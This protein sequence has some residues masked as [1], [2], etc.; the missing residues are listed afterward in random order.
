MS[1]LISSAFYRRFRNSEVDYRTGVVYIS[2]SNNKWKHKYSGWNSTGHATTKKWKC[3]FTQ[4]RI[5][6]W[7]FL[8]PCKDVPWPEQKCLTRY[9]GL[10]KENRYILSYCVSTFSSLFCKYCWH[11]LTLPLL[12][13]TSTFCFYICYHLVGSEWR[14]KWT[15]SGYL[16]GQSRPY[17]NKLQN[18]NGIAQQKFI[19]PSHQDQHGSSEAILWLRI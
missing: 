11:S 14:G 15:T 10:P 16:S 8:S 12:L 3:S 7:I 18:V 2:A 17:S 19:S 6:L 5:A 13:P 9:L 1:L 4:V